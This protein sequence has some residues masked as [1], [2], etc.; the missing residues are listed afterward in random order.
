LWPEVDDTPSAIL[1]MSEMGFGRDAG[2]VFDRLERC[3]DD[4]AVFR[5]LVRWGQLGAQKPQQED[6]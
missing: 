4:A 6:L 5:Y 2:R 3:E 1:A